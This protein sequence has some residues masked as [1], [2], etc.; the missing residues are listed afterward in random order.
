MTDFS[1]KVKILAKSRNLLIGYAFGAFYGELE[2]LTGCNPAN[3]KRG[4]KLN[5]YIRDKGIERDA[6]T[7]LARA[8]NIRAGEKV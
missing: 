4:V 5:D 8:F 1:L 7:A 3:R 2:R 6:D